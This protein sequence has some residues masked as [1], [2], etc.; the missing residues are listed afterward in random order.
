MKP[1][2]TFLVRPARLSGPAADLPGVLGAFWMEVCKRPVWNLPEP[3]LCCQPAQAVRMSA[4]CPGASAGGLHGDC[5]G[6]SGGL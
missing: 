1:V 3:S 6:L 5:P 4:A 2:W